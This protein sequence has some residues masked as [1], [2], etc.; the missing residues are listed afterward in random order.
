MGIT[1]RLP[2][3]AEW[4]ATALEI[5]NRNDNWTGGAKLSGK[6]YTGYYSWG[7]PLAILNTANP[8]DSTGNTSGVQRR[9]FV[10]AS[11]QVIWDFSGN[12]WEWVSDT[13]YG[14]SCSPDLSSFYG[15]VYGNN[16]DVKPGSKAM[17]DFTG[18][19]SVPASNVYLGNLF[20]GSS[21]KVIR[22]G[23]ACITTPG[24]TGIFAANIGD[25]TANE[26]QAPSSWGISINNVG[27]RCVATPGQY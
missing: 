18:M 26:V 9:T 23:A 14:N 4:N 10:L 7:E 5:Y 25:I 21:G 19:T 11:G 17:L 3:N 27:F 8:Y 12:V 20:G 2:T 1:Y 15:R 24:V 22:G 6:L 16:W 13:I